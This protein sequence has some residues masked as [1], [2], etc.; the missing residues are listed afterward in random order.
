MRLR[1]EQ[2]LHNRVDWEATTPL[3]WIEG[4]LAL[5]GLFLLALLLA[6]P[7]EGRGRVLVIVVGGAVLL[8][9]LLAA[10]IPLSDHGYLERLPEGGEVVRWRRWLA[11][12]IRPVWSVPLEQ[13]SG[14]RSELQL[15]QDAPDSTHRLARLWLVCADGSV[16]Q[17]V[18]WADPDAVTVL[19]EAMARAGRMEFAH[20]ETDLD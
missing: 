7:I 6:V 16:R 15:F 11:L 14:I 13:V 20:Q 17:L 19:G 18:D 10:L 5:S 1:I 12:G 8:G 4:G 2:E 3:P 9:A